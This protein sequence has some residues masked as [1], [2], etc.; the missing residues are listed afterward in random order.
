LCINCIILACFRDAGK[1]INKLFASQVKENMTDLQIALE[2]KSS[3]ASPAIA[4]LPKKA[5][6]HQ[7]V[8]KKR[9]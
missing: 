4:K 2:A 7:T 9:N 5:V 3:V 6:L 8:G 1:I